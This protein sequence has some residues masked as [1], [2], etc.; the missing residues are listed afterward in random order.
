MNF[1]NP[2]EKAWKRFNQALL[3]F[4]NNFL[5][6]FFAPLFFQLIFNLK[7]IFPLIVL[8]LMVNPFLSALIIILFLFLWLLNAVLLIRMVSQIVKWEW[9]NFLKDLSFTFSHLWDYFKTMIY[10]LIFWYWF[11]TLLVIAWFLFSFVGIFLNINWDFLAILSLVWIIVSFVW[12]I[13][14]FITSLRLFSVFFITIEQWKNPKDSMEK[15]FLIWRNRINRTFSNMLLIWLFVLV[16]NIGIVL[17]LSFIWLNFLAIIIAWAI[18]SWIT[19]PFLFLLYKRYELEDN[20][21]ESNNTIEDIDINKISNNKNGNFEK[22]WKL[23]IFFIWVF[24]LLIW[25]WWLLFI[26]KNTWMWSKMNYYDAWTVADLGNIAASLQVYYDDNWK[27]PSKK[28]WECLIPWKWVWKDIGI[29]FPWWKIPKWKKTKFS[30]EYYDWICDKKWD[31]FYASL[32]KDN[33]SNNSFIL[34]SWMHLKSKTN[35]S[36]DIFTALWK[37]KIKKYEDVLK[38]V[39]SS[40]NNWDYYCVLR[41]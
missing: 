27:F 9:V 19:V 33:L 41:P 2:E 28:S 11:Y 24:V 8:E 3:I 38:M 25:I 26:S 36:W 29:Y 30:D 35:T 14:I 20:L 37:M 39:W 15:S 13:W 40:R 6:L 34:C 4:K 17:W 18:T 32:K 23:L 12:W 31:I 21:L 1:I 22:F 10:T 16:I 5:Y 7:L